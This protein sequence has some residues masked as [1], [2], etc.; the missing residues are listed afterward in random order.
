M[1]L[2]NANSME[3]VKACQEYFSFELPSI[4]LEERR[5]KFETKFIS[6]GLDC[7]MLVFLLKLV[8]LHCFLLIL[9][10]AYITTVW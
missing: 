2:F 3:T 5:K 1:K 9:S 6:N 8:K 7:V 4:Q 10:C